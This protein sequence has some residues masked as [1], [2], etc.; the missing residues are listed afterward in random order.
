MLALWARV[1]MCSNA[2]CDARHCIAD[3]SHEWPLRNTP[4]LHRRHVVL[5]SCSVRSFL[6]PLGHGDQAAQDV[7]LLQVGLWTSAGVR[8]TT[9][10]GACAWH[11]VTDAPHAVCAASGCPLLCS[12]GLL[13]VMGPKV[14][15]ASGGASTPRTAPRELEAAVGYITGGR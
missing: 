7:P 8:S 14:V 1:R 13:L 3:C 9:V 11:S 12:G 15:T 10:V 5:V 2:W 4:R 6:Q